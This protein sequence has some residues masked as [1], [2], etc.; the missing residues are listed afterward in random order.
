M[1]TAESYWLAML[2]Y[3]GAALA[4]LVVLHRYWLALLPVRL[5]LLVSGV[6]AGLLLTPAYPTPGADTMAPA[7]VVALFN[8]LFVDGWQSARTAFILLAIGCTVGA[9][10][11]ALP[12]WL[13]GGRARAAGPTEPTP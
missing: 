4:A 10:V 6:L 1:L 7:L 13:F 3:S 5:R 8:L 11:L 9:V 2:L 12:A